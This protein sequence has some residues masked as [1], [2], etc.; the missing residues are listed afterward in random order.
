[1]SAPEPRPLDTAIKPDAADRAQDLTELTE[2][3]EPTGHGDGFTVMYDGACPLCRREI[4]LYQSLT[5]LQKVRWLDVSDASA[6]LSPA[7]Q[8][9][10]M[11]RFHVRD[12]DGRLLSGAAAFVA[13]WLTM[14]GWRWLGRVGRLPGVTPVLEWFYG[15]FLHLRPTLQ[16][17]A[18]AAEVTHLPADMLADLR[19]D[20]AG[21]TGSVAIYRGMLWASRHAQVRDLAGRHI[22]VEEQHLELMRALLPPFRRSL[23]LPVWKVAGFMVG[24]LP[25]LFGPKAVF[26]TVAAVETFVDLHYQQQIS[27]LQNRPENAR[28]LEL[29]LECQQDE[30]E[31]LEEA[32][33]RQLAP[34]GLILRLWCRAIGAGSVAGVWLATRI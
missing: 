10:F 25:A 8:T 21:E 17:W 16:R 33:L 19:A 23:L 2:L 6:G 24:V 18:R 29:L 32:S 20:H 31:H 14:P 1:M 11:A 12:T 7:E 13:L 3:T 34:P 28:L 9:R 4:G 22:R 30:R 27:K 26:A 5:P 15:G